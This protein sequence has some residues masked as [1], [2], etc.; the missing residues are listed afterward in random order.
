MKKHIIALFLSGMIASSAVAAGLPDFVPQKNISKQ[1]FM[2][3][4][5]SS[6]QFHQGEDAARCRSA[7]NDFYSELVRWIS[8]AEQAGFIS[9]MNFSLEAENPNDARIIFPIIE[10]AQ[11]LYNTKQI[12]VPIVEDV[13][14]MRTGS[15]LDV[16]GSFDRET[17]ASFAIFARREEFSDYFKA[18][19]KTFRVN[20]LIQLNDIKGNKK[21]ERSRLFSLESSAESL[22]SKLANADLETIYGSSSLLKDAENLEKKFISLFSDNNEKDLMEDLKMQKDF[23]SDYKKDFDDFKARFNN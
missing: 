16:V 3:C 21:V 22:S 23:G 4:L 13:Q 9:K 19:L 10:V 18:A 15:P 6:R 11:Y 12:L 17:P 5:Y 8:E 7:V 1:D 20:L 2:N 14:Y